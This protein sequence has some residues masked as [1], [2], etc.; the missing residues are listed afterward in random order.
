VDIGSRLELFV[1]KYLIERMDNVGLRLTTPQPQETVLTFDAPWEG[2]YSAYV[3][4]L[5]DGDCYRM[6]YRGAPEY[7]G[8][9]S[10]FEVTCCAESADGVHFTKPE[11]GLFKVQG[12]RTSNVILAHDIPFSTNFAPFLDSRPG[13]SIEE[14]YK[15]LAGVGESGLHGFASAD[16]LRW[17]KVQEEPFFQ[18]PELDSQ[19]VG[20]WSVHEGCYVCYFRTWSEYRGEHYRWIS[21]STSDDFMSWTPPRVMDKGDAPWEQIYTN[22]TAPY[23]RAPHVYLSL[24]ARYM[25]NRPVI[26]AEEG[27]RI[28]IPDHYALDCSDNVLMSSRGGNLFDRTFLEALVRPGIGAE[29][30]SS[31]SNYPAHG[32]VQTGEH[33]LSIYIQH[34][35]GQTTGYMRRYTLRLDSFASVHAGYTG[36]EFLT[37]PFTFSGGEL[38]LNFATS[39]AGGIRVEIQDKQR[40]PLHGYHLSDCDDIVGNTCDGV[41]R[42]KD[43]PDLRALAGKPIRLRFA[44][45]DADLYALRFG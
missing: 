42:W 20:F 28:G 8:D 40:Q 21:R 44:M 37:K 22:Q 13:V 19:N 14:R 16:G 38:H 41:V 11:L 18:G 36:G 30:W 35:Y 9:G 34:N 31:R 23:F 45:K 5:H 29:N 25:P 15:A 1:D 3:T 4:V 17:R 33:E 39:A 6:Y 7:I 43:G 26:S 12:S 27:K 32:I 24:A 10:D 2:R